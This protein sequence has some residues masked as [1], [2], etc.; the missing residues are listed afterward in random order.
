[1]VMA[2][3]VGNGG[4]GEDCAGGA[5]L[6]CKGANRVVGGLERTTTELLGRVEAVECGT[7]ALLLDWES[8]KTAVGALEEKAAE[9]GSAR[10]VERPTLLGRFEVL[11]SPNTA[12]GARNVVVVKAAEEEGANSFGL[13]TVL[14]PATKTYGSRGAGYRTVCSED[15]ID[16]S[17]FIAL[18]GSVKALMFSNLVSPW[19][20]TSCVFFPLL[21]TQGS[22]LITSCLI[23]GGLDGTG[24]VVITVSVFDGELAL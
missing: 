14:L 16:F 15:S 8:P 21:I 18:V 6:Y 7:G 23:F 17:S 20:G 3:L 2:V 22:S 13:S 11:V 4:G 10:G 1:M 12:V 9:L 24:A 5:A 19:Y